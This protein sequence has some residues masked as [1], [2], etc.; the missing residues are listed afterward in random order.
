MRGRDDLEFVELQA[1]YAASVLLDTAE[2]SVKIHIVVIALL[3]R[4]SHACLQKP[5]CT[6]DMHIQ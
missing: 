5:P 1:E 6:Y 3:Q 2:K 4:R